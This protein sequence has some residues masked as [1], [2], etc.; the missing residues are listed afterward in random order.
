MIKGDVVT[1]GVILVIG[2]CLFGYML[3]FLENPE[4]I[5]AQMEYGEWMDYDTSTVLKSSGPI[6]IGDGRLYAAG[7]GTAKLFL[8]SGEKYIIKITAAHVDLIL[9]NGQSNAAYYHIRGVLPGDAQRA[10]TPVPELGKDFYFGYADGMPQQHDDEVATCEIYDFVNASTGAVRVADKGPE[11]CKTYTEETGHKCIWVCLG[12]PNYA[13]SRWNEGGN[14]WV[15]DCRIMDAF[16]EKL[17]GTGFIVDRT[18]QMWA[19]GESDNWNNTGY[20]HYISTFKDFHDR[21][22]A[23]WGIDAWYL[24]AGRTVHVG[25]VND[26]FDQLAAELPDVWL[27]VPKEILN[28]FTTRNGLMNSDNIHYSQE[29]DNAVAN[30][31]ARYISDAPGVAPIYLIQAELEATV[32]ETATAPATATAYRTDTS[33]AVAPVTWDSQPDTSEAGTTVINGTSGVQ[34]LQFAPAPSLIVTVEE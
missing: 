31:A 27:A 26:A 11:F 14:A 33:Q 16:N 28:T 32:G 3:F 15:Q 6:E 22:N 4:P 7:V 12:I 29:G 19:Q 10:V 24:I 30:A 17:K 13:I 2:A 20:D 34:T 9:M 21:A 23:A 5:D 8:Y 18:I 25:W 1:A